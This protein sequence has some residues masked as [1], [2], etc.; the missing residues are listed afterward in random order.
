MTAAGKDAEF[1]VAGQMLKAPGLASGLYVVST[2][3]GN[4]GD[5]TIRA[6][7]TRREL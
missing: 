2:P 4:L 3:I 6:L 1:A 7:Q 5:I